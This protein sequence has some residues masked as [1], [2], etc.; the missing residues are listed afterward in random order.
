MEEFLLPLRTPCVY[1]DTSFLSEG[2]AT[3][4]YEDLLQ[5]TPW[6]KTPK[7]NRWVTLMMDV[8]DDEQQKYT[9]DG[10]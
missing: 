4:A 6:E 2:E 10:G 5:N 9:A 8:P 1:H 3:A 7:I